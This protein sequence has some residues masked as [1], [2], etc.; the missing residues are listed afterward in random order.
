MIYEVIVSTKSEDGSAHIAPMGVSYEGDFIVLKPFKPSKTLDNILMRKKAVINVV[1]DV[2]IFAGSVTGR[3][4]F[5]TISLPDDTGFYLTDALNYLTLSLTKTYDDDIRSS[6]YMSKVDATTLSNFQGFNRAQAAV[7]EAS[8]LIS[9]LDL[10]PREKIKREI[11][12]LEIAI[13]KTAGEKETQ[14]W[15]WLMEKYEKHQK[16]NGKK[17]KIIG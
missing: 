1:T 9:R 13:N 16:E 7:I 11:E 8:V 15:K 2:R 3:S 14:A 10:L 12:Y 17:N 5:C 4:N 6:L